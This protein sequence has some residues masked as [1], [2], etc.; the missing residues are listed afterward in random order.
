MARDIGYHGF[1]SAPLLSDALFSDEF[2]LE[3]YNPFSFGVDSEVVTP[4]LLQRFNSAAERCYTTLIETGIVYRCQ[5]TFSIQSFYRSV[6][7]MKALE[8]QKAE[9]RDFNLRHEMHNSVELAINMA[10]KLLA[11]LD[12]DQYQVLYVDDPA[13]YRSD[14]LE[15][16]VEIVFE[17]L[18]AISNQFK[19]ADDIFWMIAIEAFLKG[20]PPH[21]QQ[22]D[23]MTPFQQRLAL[24]LINN[25]RD[26]MKGYYPAICRV[27]LACVGPYAHPTPQPNR[28]AFNILKGAMY[29]ELQQFPQLASKKPDKIRNYLPDN[30]TYDDATTDLVLTYRGGAQVITRLSALNLPAID[31]VAKNIRR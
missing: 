12:T 27:L 18:A 14:V 11:S 9:R 29:F 4:Q 15:T 7:M 8:L 16:L 20:F 10:D 2:I 17:A 31:L 1:G 26:N 6:F 24:K 13:A 22:P 25:L 28:T 30:V 5:V 3:R 23:G 19:G 21:G